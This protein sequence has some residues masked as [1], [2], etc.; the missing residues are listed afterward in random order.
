M[1]V[2]LSVAAPVPV[3]TTPEVK[4]V[5]IKLLLEGWRR[6]DQSKAL[7]R[8]SSACVGAA[9]GGTTNRSIACIAG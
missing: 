5:I 1:V 8:C 4:L 2:S 7:A 3:N 6:G 9:S